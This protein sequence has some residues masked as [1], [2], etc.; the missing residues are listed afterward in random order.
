MSATMELTKVIYAEEYHEHIPLLLTGS[1]FGVVHSI[2]NNGFNIK[3]DKNLYFIGTT[4]N[5][6]LP[7]GIHLQHNALRKLLADLTLEE[8]VKWEREK[9]YIAF[10]DMNYHIDLQYAKTMKLSINTAKQADPIIEKKS[11]TLHFLP[12]GVRRHYWFRYICRRI[13]FA[14]FGRGALPERK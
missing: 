11:D 5:G 2:F 14:T 6:S 12:A 7:F 1:Q 9:G 13:H 8:S 10:L 3:I 4:K